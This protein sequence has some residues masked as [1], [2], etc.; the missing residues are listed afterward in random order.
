[1]VTVG[2]A[3]VKQQQQQNV[4]YSQVLYRAHIK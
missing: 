1:M 2:F 3:W 4:L